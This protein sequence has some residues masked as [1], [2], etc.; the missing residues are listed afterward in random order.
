LGGE[1]RIAEDLGHQPREQIG[2][3]DDAKTPLA[4]LERERE[5]GKRRSDDRE[6]IRRVIPEP[7]R[8]GKSLG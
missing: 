2:H 1:A 3:L 4:W 7:G 6:G 5:A 8:I